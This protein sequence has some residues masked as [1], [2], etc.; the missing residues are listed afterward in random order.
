MNSNSISQKH[1]SGSTFV[2]LAYTLFFFI[3][4]IIRPSRR[5]WLGTIVIFALFLCVFF[6]Y[7]RTTSET[8]R[9]WM[10]AAT[11]V[12][13]LASFPWNA[14]ASTFFIYTAAFLPF[15]I[16]SVGLVLAFFGVE[17]LA[18]AAETW[19]VHGMY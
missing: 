6:I 8:T 3:E 13:G 7:T 17:I 12:I 5:L 4:P 16:P 14:G 11:F 18:I 1:T 15:S 9:R 19:L 10:I 2:W